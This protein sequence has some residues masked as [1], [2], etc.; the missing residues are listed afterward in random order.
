MFLPTSKRIIVSKD[1]TFNERYMFYT[2]NLG[3]V[4]NKDDELRS[5][6]PS[7]ET[8]QNL[9]FTHTFVQAGASTNNYLEQD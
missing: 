7:R 3:R 5:I 6:S 9:S 1:V 4:E 2:N 8:Y